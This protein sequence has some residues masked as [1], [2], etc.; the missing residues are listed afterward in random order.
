[1]QLR[2][3]E[4]CQAT[5]G[6]VDD[7]EFARLRLLMQRAQR[8]AGRYRR[9]RSDLPDNWYVEFYRPVCEEYARI[10]GVPETNWVNVIHHWDKAL[11]GSLEEDYGPPT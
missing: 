5:K 1:V 10:T 2:F 9:G 6:F 3:C 11:T 7:E 4:R 8:N